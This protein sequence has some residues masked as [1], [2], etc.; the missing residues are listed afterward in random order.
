MSKFILEENDYRILAYIAKHN[1]VSREKI[2]NHFGNKIDGIET[3][4]K[5][6]STPDCEQG[7]YFRIPIPNTSYILEE[8]DTIKNEIKEISSIPKG[9]YYTTDFGEKTLQDYQSYNK[10][11]KFDVYFNR[12][13]AAIAIIIS[14][15]ALLKP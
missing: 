10:S 9:I 5:N 14:I 7:D 6:L 8:Y 12:T 2:I 1:S 11:Q 4:I 15:F 3:R 13:L